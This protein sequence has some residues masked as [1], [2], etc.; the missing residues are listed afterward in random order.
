MVLPAADCTTPVESCCQTSAAVG[1]HLL[2]HA[3]EAITQCFDDGCCTIAAYQTLGR[4]DDGQVDAVTVTY[5]GQSPIAD[6]RAR[7]RGPQAQRLSFDVRLRESGWPMVR[8]EGGVIVLP[9]PLEQNRLAGVV[10]G[11]IEAMY[12]HLLRLARHRQLTPAGVRCFGGSVSPLTPLTPLA[13][14]VGGFVTVT[15]DTV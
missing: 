7:G 12:R 9:D 11:H 13:G 5:L 15:V 10:Q 6:A 4:G 1:A 2:A 8:E 3:F 14:V